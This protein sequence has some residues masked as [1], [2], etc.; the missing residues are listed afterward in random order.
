MAE[1]I[2]KTIE[3]EREAQ[4]AFET[5]K[6]DGYRLLQEG[7]IDAKTYYS[8]TRD[9]GIELG[10][11]DERDYPGR[12]P[13]FAEGFLEVLGGTGGAIGGFFTAGPVGAIAGAGAG[14]AGGSLAADFLG[15]LLAPD[16]PAP[17]TKERIK[18][19]AIIGTVDAA[20][21]AATPIAGKA[22][23]PVVEKIVSGAQ[24]AKKKIIKETPDATSRLSV[25]ERVLGLTDE[26][27]EQ[28]KKLAEEGIPLSLGQ[29]STSQGVRGVYNLLGRMPIAG[30]PAQK[31]L[32]KTFEAVDKALD[33][34]ILPSK[35]KPLSES[36]RSKLIQEFGMQSFKDWRNS[37]KS[38]YKKA[39]QELK[40][41]GNFFNTNSL[42][43]VAQRNLPRSE[44]ENMPSDVQ[45]LMSDVNVYGDF[46]VAGKKGLEK[47]VLNSDDIQALDFRL[48]D[49]AKKYDPA[50]SAAPNNI[51]Y[52]SVTAM[53][54]EMKRQL[55]NPNTKH[56]RLLAAGD[57]LF[58]EYMSVVEGKTGKEFQK[59][60]GRGALR[61]GVGR[62]P[63]QR[64]EDLYKNTFGTAKSPEA[65]KELRI[66]IGKNRL[67]TLAASYLD[68]V[69]T[70][71]LRGDKRSF[72]KLFRELGFDNVKSQKYAATKELLKDYRSLVPDPQ[73]GVSRMKSITA[74]ELYDFLNILKD[75]PEALPD[76]NTFIMRSGILR[77]AQS[78]GPAALIGTTG[79]NVGGG[80]GAFA[81][82]GL[83]RLL[84]G[85]LARPFNKNLLRDSAKGNKQ[86]QKEFI[87]KFINSIP[88]LPDIP[89]GAIAVQPAVPMVSEQLQQ[90][91]TTQ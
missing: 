38:V 50:K 71:N 58:K 77:S 16:M 85:F 18:D 36:E 86:K 84:S 7:K 15:D 67:N 90:E 88:K 75:F 20:L 66:L 78:L 8:K 22:L 35:A 1:N 12:L 9:A 26:A 25:A 55:R 49:L 5:L 70:K 69:F 59:A 79:I 4:V 31:Q 27:A 89:T 6:S 61:P 45:Q 51:A 33:A 3:D 41:Q 28:A 72:D 19:A 76:V 23:K 10:L 54:D 43:V 11:I 37:Y 62:P 40:K 13:R 24:T 39:E 44:F 52:R 74:D 63:S 46:F 68:D 29:A 32:T 42:R 73:T 60:L 14:A 53:Q 64:L 48:K 80:A 21:T 17:S 2:F 91:P 87:E 65:V 82:F 34:R 81:G 57:R 47:K 83:L 56:G 30:A